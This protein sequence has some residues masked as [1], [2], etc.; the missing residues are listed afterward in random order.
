MPDEHRPPL[1]RPAD[2]AFDGDQLE[3]VEL[4]NRVLDRGVVIHG[5]VTIAVADVD[6]VNLDLTL[7]LTSVETAAQRALTRLARSETRA[8][9]PRHADVRVLPAAGER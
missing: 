6:L 5:E 2:H 4:L 9:E 7:V 1:L 8:G 3:L